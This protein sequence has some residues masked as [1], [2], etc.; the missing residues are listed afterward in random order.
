M[1]CCAITGRKTVRGN[2]VSHANNKTGR[3]FEANLHW[4]RFVMPWGTCKLRVSRRG[5]SQIM[6]AGGILEL[7]RETHS[8][9]LGEGGVELKK[10]LE[11]SE[12]RK[13]QSAQ[14][15]LA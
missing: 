7:L 3:N 1:K 9:K 13:V 2:R 5:L 10:R 12:Y 14:N 6:R 8:R 4:H 15:K 11:L